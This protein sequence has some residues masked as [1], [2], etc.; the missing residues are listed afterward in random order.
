LISLHA[1][2]RQDQVEMAKLCK[3]CIN[4]G[5]NERNI[6]GNFWFSHH[7]TLNS[8]LKAVQNQCYVCQIV[9]SEIQRADDGAEITFEK[10]KNSS[11][12]LKYYLTYGD[13]SDGQPHVKFGFFPADEDPG[14][15]QRGP[16][17][18]VKFLAREVSGM[19]LG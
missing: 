14:H 10:Y 2:G 7:A 11:P 1:I 13:D 6:E 18:P 15:F 12:F 3:E 8:F 16:P 17:F 4:I 19:F 9:F 5:R